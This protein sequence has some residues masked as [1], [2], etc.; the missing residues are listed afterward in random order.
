MHLL[1]VLAENLGEP[2]D[3]GVAIDAEQD[4]AL[5]LGAVVDIGKDGV[6][7]GK[8]A[9]LKLVLNL[10]EA[11]HSAAARRGVPSTSVLSTLAPS[12]SPAI[13]RAWSSSST[14]SASGGMLS[15]RS[16]MVETGPKWATASR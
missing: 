5:F 1:V 15:S 13:E 8:D 10:F 4:L 2:R 12:T 6:V 9:A 7:A 14:S 16:I 11:F 3:I